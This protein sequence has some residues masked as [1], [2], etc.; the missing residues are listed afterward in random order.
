MGHVIGVDEAGR[1]PVL[2]SMF[3]AAVCIPE[4]TALPAGV[5]DS[6]VLTPERREALAEQIQGREDCHTEIIEVTVE[7]ID[8]FA[9]RLNQLTADATAEAIG[10]VIPT[11]TED[12]R[13][14]VDACDPNESRYADRVHRTV[15]GDI[16]IIAKHRAD[17]EYQIVSAASILAKER[18]EEHVT[19]LQSEYGDIGSGY[20]SDATT[21]SFLATY[22]DRNGSLPPCARS[23]WQTCADLE[24]AKHQGTLT[25]F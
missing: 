5:R 17:E 20:P 2:G 21:R 19:T 11:G 1:G 7:E 8:A 25:D 12:I 24:K 13:G 9:G 3:V 6:K 15:S 16:D 22:F 4:H 18:R 14:V 23:S 10:S